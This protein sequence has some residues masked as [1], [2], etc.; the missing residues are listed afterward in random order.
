[1]IIFVTSGLVMFARATPVFPSWIALGQQLKILSP[2]HSEQ[3]VFS[4]HGR[5]MLWE[6]YAQEILNSPIFGHG[7]AVSSRLASF[8]SNNTHNGL[9]AVA[10]GTGAIGLLI[11]LWGAYRY[12]C[13]TAS[14]G[15]IDAPGAIG[16]TAALTAACVNNMSISFIGE[17]WRAPSLLFILFLSLHLFFVLKPG[18][19]PISRPRP[20]FSPLVPLAGRSN[21]RAKA[22]LHPLVVR[23]HGIL[24]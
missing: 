8:Y 12:T 19:L 15:Y 1:M 16:C 14:S 17:N 9:F 23:R 20:F 21:M 6:L 13:E 5:S 11:V 10:L 7:F 18:G 4:F 24:R 3:I 22:R 2:N